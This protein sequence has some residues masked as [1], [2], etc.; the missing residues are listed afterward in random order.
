[1]GLGHE[2]I[3]NKAELGKVV[4]MVVI[5]SDTGFNTPE[6][7]LMPLN[8]CKRQRPILNNRDATIAVSKYGG[9]V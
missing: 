6:K 9:R 1:M 8:T 4:I 2:E 7:V 5:S 3:G